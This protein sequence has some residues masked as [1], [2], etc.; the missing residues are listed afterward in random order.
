MHT[1]RT[2]SLDTEGLWKSRVLGGRDVCIP[3]F[4]MP[5][6]DMDVGSLHHKH[7]M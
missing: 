5:N 7:V 4:K 6:M 1:G 2:F 3:P